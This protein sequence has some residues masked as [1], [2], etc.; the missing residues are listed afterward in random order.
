MANKIVPLPLLATSNSTQPSRPPST[1]PS[2]PTRAPDSSYA[3][4]AVPFKIYLPD[5]APVIQEIVPPI[6]ESGKAPHVFFFFSLSTSRSCI[7][8]GKPT[9]LLAVLQ[10]H[11]PL[12]FPTSSK[13]PYERA[14][15]I[16]QGIL[17][18]QKAEVAW[19]ASCLCG[20]DGWV[21]VGV[22]LSVT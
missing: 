11:L 16:A 5:N 7:P 1:D 8:L 3:T 13:D 4:R 6:S 22:C 2:G 14:F 15:P 12:L 19:I 17:V 20:A 21:R 10:T 9:T 18:P